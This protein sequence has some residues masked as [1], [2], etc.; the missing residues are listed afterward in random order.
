MAGTCFPTLRLRRVRV[1]QL[2]ECGRP[3]Y[4]EESPAVD[5]LPIHVTT[6]GTIS[7]QYEEDYEEG[8]EFIQ[9]TG[10]GDLCINDRA[11]SVLKRSMVTVNFCFV[12]PE[13]FSIILGADLIV[14]GNGNAIGYRRSEGLLD[15]NFALEG[16]VGVPGQA[17]TDENLDYGYILFPFVTDAKTSAVTFENGTTSFEMAGWTKPGA[18]WGTGPYDVY[19]DYES[20]ATFG[21][22]DPAVGAL[23][24]YRKFLSNAPLPTPACGIVANV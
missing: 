14:D 6:D 24:H 13:L 11:N 9:K 4:A 1:T 2:D 7:L 8:D 16:W 19:S 3:V 20:P 12:D 5:D 22:L 17:C 10:W 15:S 18:G 23:E 21:P